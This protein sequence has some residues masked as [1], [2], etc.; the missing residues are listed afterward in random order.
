MREQQQTTFS[1]PSPALASENVFTQSSLLVT[2]EKALDWIDYLSDFWNKL[3]NFFSF[4]S[5]ILTG[6]LGPWLFNKIK[7]LSKFQKSTENR[8]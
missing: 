5:G 2:V 4:I 7:R 1:L 8:E 6:T 3:G